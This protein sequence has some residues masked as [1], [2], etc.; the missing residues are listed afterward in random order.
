MDRSTAGPQSDQV[1]GKQLHMYMQRNFDRTRYFWHTTHFLTFYNF[2]NNESI[3]HYWKMQ[4][5]KN[6]YNNLFV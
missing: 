3:V 6:G 2:Y 1:Q 4:I 5:Q